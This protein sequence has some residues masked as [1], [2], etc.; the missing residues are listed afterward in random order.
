MIRMIRRH[1]SLH[2]LQ[3]ARVPS[4]F[5]SKPPLVSSFA[6]FCRFVWGGSCLLVTKELLLHFSPH[7][8]PRWLPQACEHRRSFSLEMKPT[9][10]AL[11]KRVKKRQIRTWSDIQSVS[12]AATTVVT[13]LSSVFIGMLNITG[14]PFF[15]PN[16]PGSLSTENPRGCLIGL[17]STCIV[18]LRRYG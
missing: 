5:P 4:H 13:V 12:L 17:T 6:M 15:S 3:D 7:W 9:A 11:S 16:G 2:Q 18:P 10:F 14:Y 1:R 8:L